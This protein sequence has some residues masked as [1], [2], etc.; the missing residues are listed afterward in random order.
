[1]RS[2]TVAPLFRRRGAALALLAA[3]VPLAG[4]CAAPNAEREPAPA[5]A[6][7]RARPGDPIFTAYAEEFLAALRDGNDA[8]AIRHFA[9]HLKRAYTP[10]L[11]GRGR[12][13]LVWSFGKIVSW[14][15]ASQATDGDDERREYEVTCA[16]SVVRAHFVFHRGTRN[17]TDFNVER[18]SIYVAAPVPGSE[19]AVSWTDATVGPGLGA[20]IAAPRNKP[21]AR[22]PAVV[23]VHDIAA[24]DRDA[25]I[26]PLRAFRDLGDGLAAR[27]VVTIRFDKRCFSTPQFCGRVFTLEEDM[28]Q[29]AVSAVAV[30]RRDPSVDPT[31]VILVAHGVGAIAAA[32]IAR[33]AGDIAGVVLLG[34]TA[35]PLLHTVLEEARETDAPQDVITRLVSGV[36]RILDG[37]ARPSDELFGVPASFWY[38]L[39]K[40][41]PFEDVRRLDRPV[42]LV[43]GESDTRA[44]ATDQVRWAE[45]LAP[46]GKKLRA[47]SVPFVNHA[48]VSMEPVRARPGTPTDVGPQVPAYLVDMVAAFVTTTTTKAPPLA[49]AGRTRK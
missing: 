19:D 29:D 8:V 14:R 20:T 31:R 30:V 49:P 23:L 26:G 3:L 10:A 27:G 6:A 13:R 39:A 2:P 45:E 1:M 15:A 17:L 41:T 18:E 44:I 28:I 25:T 42:L 21:E 47:E 35:R 24:V 38:D 43:R 12:E 37:T 4:G 46:L 22:L 40:R 16:R 11:F 36:Q 32:E 48:L 5:R 9:A 7:P 33:R 34:A